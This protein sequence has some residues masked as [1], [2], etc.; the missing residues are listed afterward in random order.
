MV[1]HLTNQV[2]I[3][4][5]KWRGKNI[6]FNNVVELRPTPDRIRETLFNW[7]QNDIHGARC[8]D[9]FAGSGILSFEALSRG[10]SHVAMME[11][12]AKIVSQLRTHIT[13]LDVNTEAEVQHTDCLQQLSIT[14]A[15]PFNIVFL[16]PPY[17][18]K[19]LTT[20]LTQLQQY[21]WLAEG[22]LIYLE[23]NQ[24]LTSLPAGFI[25]HRERKAGKVYYG[26]CQQI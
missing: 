4:A 2:R 6:T 18:G 8:L 24:P 16:D 13:K 17:A 3:I 20:C 1:T 22:A 21:G 5:G 12:D 11:T 10:A 14:P 23:D 19:H 25:L 26:L 9:C 15:N 7:L